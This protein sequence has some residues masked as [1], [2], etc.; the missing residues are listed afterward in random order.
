MNR[1]LAVDCN[2]DLNGGDG[3]GFCDR[4][5]GMYKKVESTEM[6]LQTPEYRAFLK[7]WPGD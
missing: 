1:F 5:G 7:R 2:R 6:T 4:K 3:V